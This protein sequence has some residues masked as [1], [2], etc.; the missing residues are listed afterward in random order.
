M[1][2]HSKSSYGGAD[3]MKPPVAGGNAGAQSETGGLPN[4]VKSLIG[5]RRRRKTS[6]GSRKKRRS[7]SR[8]HRR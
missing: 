1:T 6:K 3:A 7:K 2:N 5:G 4:M 8:K